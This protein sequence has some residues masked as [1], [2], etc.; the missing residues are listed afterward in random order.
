MTL[1]IPKALQTAID[2]A[3]VDLSHASLD[4]ILWEISNAKSNL[5]TSEEYER[6]SGSKFSGVSEI[7][8]QVYPVYERFLLRANSVDFDDLLLHVACMLRDNP[9]LRHDLDQRYKYIMVDEYQDTNLAQY[10][11]VRALSLSNQNLSVTGDPDQSIYAWRGASISTF[12]NLKRLPQCQSRTL[13][14]EL[15]KY[16]ADPAGRGTTDRKQQ[17]AKTK[18]AIYRKR[19]RGASETGLLSSSQ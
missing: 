15:S 6:E 3:R 12:W 2:E 13:G 19:R 11:I 5:R 9:D 10:A 18:R 8:R 17:A 16:E 4:T 1:K 7:T 14:T